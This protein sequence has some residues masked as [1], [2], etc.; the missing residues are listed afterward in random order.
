M[1][2]SRVSLAL[3]DIRADGDPLLRGAGRQQL[4]IQLQ[5]LGTAAHDL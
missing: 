1:L 4:R 2:W 5:H 3:Q